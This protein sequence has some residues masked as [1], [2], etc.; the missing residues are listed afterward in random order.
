MD[1]RRKWKNSNNEQGRKNY[2]TLRNGLKRATEEA[3]KEYL[4]RICDDIIEFQRRG[5]FDLI[6]VK[7]KEIGWKQNQG[8]QNIG[9]EDTQAN[10]IVDRDTY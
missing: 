4:E 8:I 2:R 9:I 1:E 6:H 7:T 3:K 10:V 5:H